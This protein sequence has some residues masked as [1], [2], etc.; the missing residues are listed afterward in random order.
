MHGFRIESLDVVLASLQ[1]LGT[2]I[3]Q[4][5]TDSSWGLRA[6]VLDPDGRAVEL[7]QQQPGKHDGERIESSAVFSER[8]AI[9]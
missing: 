6:V 5:P 8:K 2:K 9:P 4:S 3:V 7:T 1:A